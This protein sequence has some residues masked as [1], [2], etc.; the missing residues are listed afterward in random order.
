MTFD[1]IFSAKLLMLFLTYFFF[2]TLSNLKWYPFKELKQQLNQVYLK[3]WE[4]KVPTWCK[5]D[6]NILLDQRFCIVDVLSSAVVKHF[7]QGSE[8]N[9]ILT[10]IIVLSITKL[11]KNPYAT[12]HS[13][14]NYWIRI[15]REKKELITSITL[16][17]L[18]NSSQLNIFFKLHDVVIKDQAPLHNALDIII[19]WFCR[20]WTLNELCYC[21]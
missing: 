18:V 10:K 16:N 4:I 13:L 3:F 14:K 11:S 21:H 20:T 19:P 9:S 6:Q 15:C 2:P 17:T 5:S 8:V 1:V 7:R 12:I